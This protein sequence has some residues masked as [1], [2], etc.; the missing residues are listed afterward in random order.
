MILMAENVKT[1]S[2]RTAMHLDLGYFFLKDKIKEDEVK[3]AFALN[4]KW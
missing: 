3:V 4:M 1:S 2:S